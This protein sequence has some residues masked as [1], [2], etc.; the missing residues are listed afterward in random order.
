MPKPHL[1]VVQV[2]SSDEVE[3]VTNA[4][5]NMIVS[6][7]QYI[8]RIKESMELENKMKEKDLIM[9]NHLKDAQ[10]KYLV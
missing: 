2:N 5:N 8:I 1:D 6:I 3:V 7:H 9:T 4:F 10:L